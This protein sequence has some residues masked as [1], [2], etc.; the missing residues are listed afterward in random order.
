MALKSTS[1]PIVISTAVTE[2]G[3]NTFTQAQIDLQ[4]N[5]LDREVFVVQAVDLDVGAPDAVAST[6]TIVAVSLTTT[7]Q[8]AISS[9]ANTNCLAA[10]QKEIRSAN[11][12]SAVS[13][14]SGSFESPPTQLDYIGIIATNDFFLQIVGAN[15]TAAKNASCKVYG[16]RAQ[17]D[18][19]TYAAL[20]QSEILS[21]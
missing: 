8:T 4:L 13:F 17:A 20:V 18:S 15:N 19:A 7:T 2:S 11:A 1:S 9:L 6:N 12:T 5:V 21:S 3:A 14:E 16:Y 10:K